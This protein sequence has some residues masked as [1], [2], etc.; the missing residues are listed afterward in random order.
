M[1][2]SR[3]IY[4]FP[5][6]VGQEQLKLALLLNAVNPKIGGVLVRGEKGT[7]KS[8]AV[9]GLGELL[10]QI[11]AV[12][13]CPYTCDPIAVNPSCPHCRNRVGKL[14]TNSRPI[15]VV[16]LPLNATEDR[17]SGGIDF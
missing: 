5:A 13:G 2:L 7:A 15:R 10:P 6:L 12:R 14:V 11:D 3:S 8:T 9:R 1:T 17:V 4:P 16:T